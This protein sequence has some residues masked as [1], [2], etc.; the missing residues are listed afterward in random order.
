MQKYAS[1]SISASAS[2]SLSVSASVAVSEM[3]MASSD[4]SHKFDS[5]SILVSDSQHL[6]STTWLTS[7]TAVD[8]MQKYASE[9]ISSSQSG[10][11]ATKET[12]QAA[13]VRTVAKEVTNGNSSTAV[14]STK[15]TAKLPQTGNAKPVPASLLGGVGLFLAGLLGRKKRRDHNDK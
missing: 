1:E 4:S 12:S 14:S 7:D 8:D 10:V 13:L 3:L 6:D 15:A 5:E 2:H 11:T 9:S